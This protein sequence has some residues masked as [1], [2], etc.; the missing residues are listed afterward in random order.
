M[1]LSGIFRDL[2][3]M[4]TKMLAEAAYKAAMAD[5]PVEQNF[6]RAHALAHAEEMGCDL[7]TAAV[8]VFSNAEGVYGSNVN[9]LVDNGTWNDEDELAEAFTRARALPMAATASPGKT[10]SCCKRRWK[11]SMWPTRTWSPS[12][13][14]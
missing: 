11:P 13:W 5:E 1:T 4:Q 12:S 3:P 8:R 14:A 7:E 2:L 9:Q 6:V 10:S